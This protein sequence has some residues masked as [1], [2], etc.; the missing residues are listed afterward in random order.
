VSGALGEE[1]ASRLGECLRSGGVAVFPTDTV[2]G[3]GCDPERR[4]AVE[5][6]YSLK[7]RS[8]DRPAAVMFLALAEALEALPALGARERAAI[9][10]L[11][12]GPVTVLLPNR[13]RRFALACGP[14]PSSLGLRVPL[15]AAPL[16]ALRAVPGPVLQSSANLSGSNDARR[17]AEVPA[18]LRDGADL[19]LDGGELPGSASTVVDLRDYERSG[20]WRVLR[21]G[22]LAEEWLADALADC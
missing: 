13:E 7:G 22:P 8:A 6:L 9:E 16:S 19:V 5:R 12:P 11:L 14:D 1:H 2:Y 21:R 10:A 4:S 17:L 18:S 3:L 20:D 15:L